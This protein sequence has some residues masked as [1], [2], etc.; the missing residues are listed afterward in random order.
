[1]S[2]SSSLDPEM[3]VNYAVVVR[4]KLKHVGSLKGFY[5]SFPDTK[6]IFSKVSLNRLWVKE[7]NVPPIMELE[8]K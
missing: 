8:E 2:E 4:T 6:T 3:Y 1:M 5:D 7:D